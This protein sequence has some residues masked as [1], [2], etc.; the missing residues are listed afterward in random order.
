MSKNRKR[1][2]LGL[3]LLALIVIGVGT[4]LFFF[5]KPKPVYVTSVAIVGD[6]EKT[7]LATGTLLDWRGSGAWRNKAKQPKPPPRAD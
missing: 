3:A 1:L 5:S 7:V 4:K 6:V 2:Y